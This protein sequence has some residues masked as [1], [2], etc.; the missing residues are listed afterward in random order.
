M[1]DP[2]HGGRQRDHAVAGVRLRGF[3]EGTGGGGVFQGPVHGD[4]A[5][6]PVHGGILQ[7]AD[8]PQAQAAEHGQEDGQLQGRLRFGDDQLQEGDHFRLRKGRLFLFA[9]LRPLHPVHGVIFQQAY[10]DGSGQHGLHAAVIVQGR[11]HAEGLRGLGGGDQLLAFPAGPLQLFFRQAGGLPLFAPE[12]VEPVG[13]DCGGEI[14]QIFITQLRQ[15]PGGKQITVIRYGDR[16]GVVVQVFCQPG[17]RPLPEGGRL[18]QFTGQAGFQLPE[19]ALGVP[20][21]DVFRKI[22]IHVQRGADPLPFPADLDLGADA[23]GVFSAFFH[24]AQKA[25]P[26]FHVRDVKKV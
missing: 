2:D 12:I 3:D 17:F 11:L 20:A 26:P 10:A 18:F 19:F 9:L 24:C 21:L 5:G 7:G 6:I 1:E 25:A 13:E 8:F 4:G 22:R 16:A 23:P 14:R 15:D